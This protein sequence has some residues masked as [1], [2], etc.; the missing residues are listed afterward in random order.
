MNILRFVIK[1]PIIFFLL[2]VNAHALLITD[3]VGGMDN[4]Y[5]ADWGHVFNEGL[6]DG[7][8]FNALGTGVAASAV[9]SGVSVFNFTGANTINISATGLV[10]DDGQTQT[11]ANGEPS[12]FM[13]GNWRGLPAYS[14]IGVWSTSATE[15]M[16]PIGSLSDPFFIGTQL[17]LS[18]VDIPQVSEL[19]LFLAENDGLFGDNSGSYEVTLD[20][21]YVPIPASG[22]LLLSG[23][24]GL[25]VSRRKSVKK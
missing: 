3:T 24:A 18:L 22:L 14:L 1:L 8:Q 10:V 23:L 4:L 11:D 7:S 20:V 2:M 16:P 21:Q 25:F 17:F 6:G 12:D 5:F 15:I 9:V 19:Y 13:D